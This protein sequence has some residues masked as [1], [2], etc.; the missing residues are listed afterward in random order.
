MYDELIKEIKDYIGTNCDIEITE[1][2]F[3][4]SIYGE[5]LILPLKSDIIKMRIISQDELD[6]YYISSS[7][8]FTFVYMLNIISSVKYVYK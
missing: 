7:C 8:G 6:K 1:D 2:E 3:K 4:M 5:E